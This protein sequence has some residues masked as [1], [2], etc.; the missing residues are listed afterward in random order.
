MSALTR[1]HTVWGISKINYKAN[2]P[3]LYE[4]HMAPYGHLKH[5]C[6]DNERGKDCGGFP[7]LR[8]FPNIVGSYKRYIIETSIRITL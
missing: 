3:T 6:F 2:S 8:P 5:Y 1:K 4:Y 7:H